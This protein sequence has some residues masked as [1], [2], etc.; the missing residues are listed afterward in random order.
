MRHN[1]EAEVETS[2]GVL[3]LSVDGLERLEHILDIIVEMHDAF[4]ISLEEAAGRFDC[5]AQQ[6]MRFV[7]GEMFFHATAED[8]AGGIYFGFDEWREQGQ[9]PW[10]RFGP[11]EWARRGRNPP[12]P[13]P[14][15]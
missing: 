1:S 5:Y 10:R 12:M 11:E 15:P 6:C 7:N 3:T 2:T 4:G 13:L 14:Y 8:L 9:D